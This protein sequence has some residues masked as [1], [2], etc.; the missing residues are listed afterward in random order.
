[1]VETL[2]ILIIFVVLFGYGLG[3]FSVVHTAIMNSMA[4]RTYTFETLSNRSDVTLFR[5]RAANGVYDEYRSYGTRFHTVNSELKMTEG[6]PNTQYAT[7]RELAFGRRVPASKAKESDHNEK[8]YQ[9]SGRNSGQ[10]EASPAWVMVG[11]GICI[12]AQCG[13]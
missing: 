8:I 12:D 2:P 9:L 3:L 6:A 7:T 4:A 10:V 5:D 13:D 11:Y 1:M